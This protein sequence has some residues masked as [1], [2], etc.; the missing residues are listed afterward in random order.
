MQ[1][2]FFL[3]KK[4]YFCRRK[5]NKFKTYIENLKI[6]RTVIQVILIVAICVVA[7]FVIESVQKP[8]RFNA[9]KDIRYNATVQ[10]LKEIRTAQVA[11]RSEYKRYT[12]SFDTLVEFLKTDSFN[13][14]MQIGDEDDSVAVSTGSIIRKTIR[15]SVLDSLFK[16]GYHVDSIRYA[17]FTQGVEFALGTANLIAG[18]VNVNVFEAK[19]PFDVLLQGLDPQLLVN[20]SADYQ[21]K[22]GYAGLKVGSL[23][24][25]TNN[26]G[27]FE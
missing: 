11:F 24:E 9:E 21:K 4:S 23:T 10:R 1:N 26:A 12:G 14:V 25:T 8:L 5:A 27:N 16:K 18:N 22:T 6:M 3:K 20:Y 13:V 7:Y 17:P 15:V 2:K 19:I